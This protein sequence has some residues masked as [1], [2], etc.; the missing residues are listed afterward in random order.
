MMI[1]KATS[2][3][4]PAIIE[5]SKEFQTC[6]TALFNENERKL[7]KF[8]KNHLSILRKF[9]KKWIRSQDAQVFVAELNGSIEGFM[10]A[11]INKIASVYEHEKEIH[12][13]GIFIRE[14]FRKK[15]IGKKFLQAAE[16]WAKKKGIFSIGLTVLI[17]NK[18]ASSAYKKLGFFAH[19]YKMSKIVK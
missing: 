18:D 19:N 1:R 5:C 4:I 3:D 12:I 7:F 10:M 16:E 11:T 15:G 9:L 17:K 6:G 8:K 2:K 13:E 14:G